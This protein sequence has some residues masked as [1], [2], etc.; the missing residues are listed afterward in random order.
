MLLF[1]AHRDIVYSLLR[2]ENSPAHALTLAD[3]ESPSSYGV[4]T[5]STRT[6]SLADK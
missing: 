5:P 2:S 6:L 4:Q 1:L 3:G